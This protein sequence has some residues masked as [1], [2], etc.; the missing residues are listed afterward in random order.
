MTTK[1]IIG[2]LIT[3]IVAIGTI[4]FGFALNGL[5]VF[6]VCKILGFTFAWKWVVLFTI[7]YTVIKSLFTSHNK[8]E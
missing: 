4:A 8:K 2:I 6:V 1:K 3:I 5:I 7:A